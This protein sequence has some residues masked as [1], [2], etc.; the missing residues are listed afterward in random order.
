MSRV[1]IIGGGVSA[2]RLCEALGRAFAGR[3]TLDIRLVGRDPARLR[4]LAAAAHARCVAAAAGNAQV[5]AFTDPAEGLRDADVVVLLARVGGFDARRHDETFPHDFGL[6]GDEGLGPGGVANAW[7]T[8]PWMNDWAKRIA[9][10]APRARVANMMAPLGGTTQALEDAG[11]DVVGVCELPT[12][13]RRAAGGRDGEGR[14]GGLNHLGWFWDLPCAPGVL[15]LK[16]EARVFD[17]PRGAHRPVHA[18]RADVLQALDATLLAA[19]DQAPDRAP[20]A[21]GE[22]PTPWFDHALIPL[23]RAW[24]LDDAVHVFLTARND[25]ALPELPA[26]QCVELEVAVHGRQ[27]ARR[28]PGP[29]PLQVLPR[30]LAVAESERWA[31]RAAQTRQPRDVR[32]ALAALP[33]DLTRREIGALAARVMQPLAPYAP[34]GGAA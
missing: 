30:L 15:P 3:A 7:R 4:T 1:A 11:L 18:P 19:F 29:L 33:F 14:Y 25:G 13:T 28:C 6:V 12:L 9:A 17:E 34:S 2:P 8:V 26:S 31:Y 10:H 16:Y 21:E 24:C 32:R 22:R 23:I 5:S 20:E 27:R